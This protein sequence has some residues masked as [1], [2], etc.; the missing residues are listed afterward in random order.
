MGKRKVAFTGHS[1]TNLVCYDE[2]DKSA[3]GKELYR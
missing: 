3:K 1:Q 2:T